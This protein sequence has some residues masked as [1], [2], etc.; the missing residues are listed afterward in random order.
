ML[1]MLVQGRHYRTIWLREDNPSIV[2]IID[3]RHLPH[4]FV[5]EDLASVDDVAVAIAD[6]HLRG[7]GLIGAAAGYGMYLAALH[8]PRSSPE[9]FMAALV[10]DGQRLKATRPTAVNLEWAVHRQLA[11]IEAAGSDPE[12]RTQA[13]LATA[14]AIADEDADYCRRIGQHGK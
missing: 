8:A 9:A 11:A 4:R 6:M 2:Q 7:A 1:F 10:R 13:A 3:Q 5:V 12:A 14:H